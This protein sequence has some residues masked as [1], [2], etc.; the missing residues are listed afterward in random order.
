MIMPKEKRELQKSD[1]MPF[2]AYIKVRKAFA[3]NL[4][5]NDTQ[6]FHRDSGSFNLLKAIVYL[7][8]VD[9]NTGPFTY[10][11][12]THNKFDFPKRKLRFTDKEI[13]NYY[14]KNKIKNL[15]AKAGDLVLANTTGFH[16][17][18][19][20]KIFDRNVCIANFWMRHQRLSIF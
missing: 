17:G 18:L 9:I 7:N 4:P 16:K 8:D 15:V 20:P 14:G 12:G 3:N 5:A 11:E 13:S 19:K 6:F 10:T 2:D 1:I